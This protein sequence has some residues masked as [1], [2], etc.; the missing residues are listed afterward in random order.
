[1]KKITIILATIVCTVSFIISCKKQSEA[2]T[3]LPYLIKDSILINVDSC[4]N[5]THNNINCNI[6][7]DTL[8]NDSRCP[9]DAICIW[10]GVAQTRF[11][12][13]FNSQVHLIRLATDNILNY[14]TDTT[15]S[16]ITFHL[17][18]LTPH[19]ATTI[20]YPYSAYKAKIIVSN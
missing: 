2:T 1:M 11:K 13:N 8:L 20:F 6:C 19:P 14:K 9:I 18:E 17:E 3:T 10:Q 12:V 5:I 16:G 15:I 4:K 7:F